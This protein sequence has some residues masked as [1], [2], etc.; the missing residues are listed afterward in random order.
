MVDLIV[1]DC[2]YVVV[3]GGHNGLVAANYLAKTGRSVVVLEQRPYLGGMAATQAHVAAAPHHLL[4]KGAIDSIFMKT[5]Q[6]AAELQLAQHGLNVIDVDPGYGWINE[7]GD[8][9]CLFTSAEK[10][11][12]NIARFSKK[13]ASNYLE[14]TNAFYKILGLQRRFFGKAIT[15]AGAAD[16]IKVALTLTGDRKT[17]KLLWRLASVSA[18]EAIAETFESEALRGLYAYWCAIAC[19]PDVDGGGIFL[20]SLALIH[21]VGCSRPQRGMGGLIA[22]LEHSLLSRGGVIRCNAA[23]AEIL[24]DDRRAQG[25]RLDDGNEIMVAR[26]VLTSCAPQ[27]TYGR[28][29]KPEALSA[30]IRTRLNHM[31]ANLSN[32]CP[33]KVDMAI[34]GPSLFAK[35]QQRRKQI[36]GADI[37]GTSFM[38]GTLAEHMDHAA[39][40]RVGRMGSKPPIWMTVLSAVDPSIAP[41]GQSVAYLYGSVPWE[42]EGG[43]S[44]QA[45][46]FA[47]Q[48]VR[49]ASRYLDGLSAEIGRCVT[50]PYDFEQQY[51]VPRG[52]I[53]HVDMLPTRLGPNRPASGM[54]G[55]RTEIRNLYLAGSGSHPAGGVF[56]MP[57]KLAA[58]EALREHQD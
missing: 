14:L 57:G 49:D 48:L 19:P 3:G 42:P 43:W 29:L 5:T 25:V 8:T 46:I 21:Q 34:G 7:E 13:D 10:T 4:S 18:H 11:A 33:F 23:V 32:M 28:L 1:T 55:A 27:V 40:L 47:D 56:G 52:C 44:T 15:E 39:A 2:D 58:M 35:A 31:P 38:T 51:A 6:I 9:L 20:S 37:A 16:L 17:R 54:S 50:T 45:G 30:N 24:V 53:Y 36:D 26:G 22:A 41:E 12:L